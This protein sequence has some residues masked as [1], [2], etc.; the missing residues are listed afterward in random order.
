MAKK[1]NS[2]SGTTSGG[3]TANATGFNLEAYVANVLAGEGYEDMKGSSQEK[4]QAFMNRASIGG[5]QYGYQV[6][7]GPTIYGT[8]RTVDFV[9]YN[10]DI[11]PRSLIIECKWQ[12]SGGSVDEK[13]PFLLDCVERTG[14]ETGAPCIVILDGGGYR[15]EAEKW[16]HEQVPER[17]YLVAVFT[18][19]EFQKAVNK[20]LFQQP[21]RETLRKK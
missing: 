7:V 16:V 8:P 13:Y 2:S 9:V 12:Q 3:A 10:P 11:F 19:S 18:M 15:P 14:E 21:L 4:H 1:K 17:E 20:G 6:L 5:R